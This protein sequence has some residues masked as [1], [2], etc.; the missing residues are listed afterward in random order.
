MGDNERKDVSLGKRLGVKTAWASYGLPDPELVKRLVA[1]SP[2][3]NVHKN[4]RLGPGDPSIKPDYVLA[5]F[6]DILK[7]L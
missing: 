2:E 3:I 1:F 4:A 5:T 7:Y 6:A